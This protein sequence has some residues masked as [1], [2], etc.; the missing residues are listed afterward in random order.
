M[1][2][3]QSIVETY[4]REVRRDATPPP[5]GYAVGWHG[6]VLRM[7]GPGSAVHE[8]GVLATD[9]D[10]E[11]ADR[12]IAHEI[13]VFRALGRPFEWKLHAYDTPGDLAQRLARAG[14]ERGERET[15][16]A[17][18]LNGAFPASSPPPEVEFVRLDDPAEF[19]PIEA[20]KAVT[21]GDVEH[22]RWLVESLR[23]EKTADPDSI[24]VHVARVDGRPVSAGWL[25]F[26]QWR[27]IAS[28]WGG[29]TLPAWR[30]RGVYTELVARRLA[31]ARE[32]GY[33]HVTVDC[34]DNSLPILERRGFRP[35]A[36]VTPWLWHPDQSDQIAR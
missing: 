18:D 29:S 3:H 8:N 28:L 11:G 34:S 31:E 9:L 24:S 32:R 10:A 1:E 7:V 16:V 17:F 25:R 21:F 26:P 33:R 13:A 20:L 35:L 4:E 23:V 36:E 6:G 27:S 30:R 12:T 22:A 15:L 5:G 14:F 19:G 2:A